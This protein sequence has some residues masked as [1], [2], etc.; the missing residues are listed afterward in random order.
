MP[1]GEVLPASTPKL[2]TQPRGV[3]DGVSVASD[4][5]S[6]GC[7]NVA[8]T[9]TSPRIVSAQVVPIT[10]PQAPPHVTTYPGSGV[11]VNATFVGTVN[12]AEHSAP[13]AMP[14]GELVTTPCPAFSTR[15]TPCVEGA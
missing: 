7:A 14:V 2:V 13:Q 5:V 10:P 11:A 3:E 12:S 9:E 15:S 4:T 6:V 8:L 1:C